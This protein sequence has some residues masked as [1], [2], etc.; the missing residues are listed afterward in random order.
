MSSSVGLPDKIATFVDKNGDTLQNMALLA[1]LK[2]GEEAKPFLETVTTAKVAVDL[3][4]RV[5]APDTE[6]E[7]ARAEVIANVANYVKAHPRARPQEIQQFVEG[8]VAVF[9]TKI[10]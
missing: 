10:K 1:Y 2:K 4:R 5:T 8:Q 6:L 9:K 7:V 3:Y